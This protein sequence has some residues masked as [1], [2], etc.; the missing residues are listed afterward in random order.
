[1]HFTRSPIVEIFCYKEHRNKY[2]FKKY[3]VSFICK[4]LTENVL[5]FKLF[6]GCWLA[7]WEFL[8]SQIVT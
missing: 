4:E 8:I 5:K 2:M 1:M 3:G 6:I 7:G